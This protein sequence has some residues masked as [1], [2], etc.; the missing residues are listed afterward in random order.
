VLVTLTTQRT[1]ANLRGRRAMQRILASL[2]RAKE[3]LGRASFTTR[4]SGITCT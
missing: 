3:R 1:V 2:S 4:C